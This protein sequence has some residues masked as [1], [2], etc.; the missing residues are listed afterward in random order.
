MTIDD[1]L[2]MAREVWQLD[3]FSGSEVAKL[4]RFASL[5]AAAEREACEDLRQQRDDLHD[6]VEKLRKE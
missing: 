3:Y 5:V 4:E 1:I 2:K 6:E